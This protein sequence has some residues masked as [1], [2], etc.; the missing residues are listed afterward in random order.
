MPAFLK[1]PHLLLVLTTLIWGGNAIAGKLAVGHISPMMLTLARW[2]I[3]L[4]I[5][6]AFSWPRIRDDW[7]VIRRN[8]LYLVAM[9]GV[10]FTFFNFFLYS[11][12]QFT[13]AINV[14]LEQ[15][16]M[17][18]FIF[19]ANYLLYR[20]GVTWLQI[21]GYAL[22]LLGV[23]VTV[24]HGD[25]VGLVSGAN[26]LNRGD[27]L[28][29]GA[30]LCY[31]GYSVALR[32]KPAMHWQSFLAALIFGGA[33][34]AIFGAA[35]E[36]ALG[37]SQ[38]PSTGQGIAVALYAGIFPSLVSQGLFIVAVEKLGANRAGLYINLVPVFGA[39][40]AVAILGEA[41]HLFHAL[42]FLLVVGGILIAQRQRI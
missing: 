2:L 13:S 41:L 7:P 20:I 42:A 11:A 29:I 39:L 9:G 37:Y 15:S 12:L 25:P 30:A 26:E 17:P 38:F 40:L 23:V 33:L 31:A 24:S 19:A 16:A 14:T 22:T 10:G 34:F 18:L 5:I 6:S 4:A 3:A 35:L 36:A 28:M 21:L 27:A 8:W 1:N 32:Q